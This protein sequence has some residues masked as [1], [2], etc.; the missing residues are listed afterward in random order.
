MGMCEAKNIAN[1]E[2]KTMYLQPRNPLNRVAIFFVDRGNA[3][4]AL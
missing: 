3:V 1:G 4:S 2:H